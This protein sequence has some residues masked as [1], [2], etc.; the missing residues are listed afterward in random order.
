M[1]IRDS[2]FAGVLQGAGVVLREE[3]ITGLFKGYVTD[4]LSNPVQINH[5]LLCSLSVSM[6]RELTFSST[7]M[8]L[9]E[10]IRNILAGPNGWFVLRLTTCWRL[11]P[12]HAE[13]SLEK[14]IISG[15]ISGAL[16]AALFNPTDVLKVR[17]P[18]HRR[19]CTNRAPRVDPLPGGQVAHQGR[20]A[21][22]QRGGR[23]P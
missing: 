22:P 11:P 20:A 17:A 1:S 9:Y 4:V 13:I 19:L 16:A 21:V 14:K 10:P 5:F 2:P 23:L 18:L 15:L 3:G 7:R 8:G 6:L 12:F